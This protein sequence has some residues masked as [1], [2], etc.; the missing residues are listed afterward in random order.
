MAY[1]VLDTTVVTKRKT[2]SLQ[3]HRTP[4]LLVRGEMGRNEVGRDEVG[5]DDGPREE[6]YNSAAG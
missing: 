4:A 3:S 6:A 2:H 5:R 1:P